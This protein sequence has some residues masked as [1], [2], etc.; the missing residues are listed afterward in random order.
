MAIALILA[1]SATVFWVLDWRNG[2]SHAGGPIEQATD[3]YAPHG[4]ASDA[5]SRGVVG[6]LRGR[7]G[8]SSMLTPDLARSGAGSPGE[9][10]GGSRKSAV[11][12]DD[13]RAVSIDGVAWT[14][15][16]AGMPREF[17]LALD[18]AWVRT[19]DGKGESV[20]IDAGDAEELEQRI[21]ETAERL[22]L[23]VMAVLFEDGLERSDVT[24]RIVTP[25]V[26]VKTHEGA[27][28]AQIA[29]AAGAASWDAPSYAPDHLV[30]QIP[31]VLA[32]L[33]AAA[34]LAS[35]DGVEF[36]EPQLARLQSKKAMPNDPLINQQWHLKFNNQT[37]AV[38][39]TD[40]NIESVWAYPTVGAGFR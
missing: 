32:P 4:E 11:S 25:A 1:L 5:R 31:G 9:G 12:A 26:T 22:S 8:D 6:N 17:V 24:R 13:S 18:E 28:P 7:L 15:H 29:S 33:R 10:E 38:A 14:I 2:L 3:T 36:A 27:D 34:M 40:L 39:G 30:L 20:A 19:P 37:G 35:V 23:P 16:D 21:S